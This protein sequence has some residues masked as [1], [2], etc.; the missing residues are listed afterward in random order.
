MAPGLACTSNYCCSYFRTT[1]YYCWPRLTPVGNR[2]S[3]FASPSSP[4]ALPQHKPTRWPILSL[5]RE[6]LYPDKKACKLAGT[7]RHGTAHA[8]GWCNSYKRTIDRTKN[9]NK[10]EIGIETLRRHGF[11]GPASLGGLPRPSQCSRCF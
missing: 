10:Q 3:G 11:T 1:C 9:K 7:H 6:N 4:F 8:T 2:R 5:S